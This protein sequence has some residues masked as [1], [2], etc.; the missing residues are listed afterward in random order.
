MKRRIYTLT[1]W[2]VENRA[3]G[4]YFNTYNNRNNK[5]EWRGPY[6]SEASVALMIA[7]QLRK[8]ITTREG[9]IKLEVQ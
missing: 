5:R 7:R 1:D 8:E 6:H 4:W 9:A 3:D 2:V